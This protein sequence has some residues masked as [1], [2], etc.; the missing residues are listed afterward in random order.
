MLSARSSRKNK[1]KRYMTLN[2]LETSLYL[3]LKVQKWLERVFGIAADQQL[4]VDKLHGSDTLII[5]E[6]IATGLNPLSSRTLIVAEGSL[7]Y[8]IKVYN[9]KNMDFIHIYN[10]H[11]EESTFAFRQKHYHSWN[12]ILTKLQ[13][14]LFV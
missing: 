4:I 8:K 10:V 2:E 3:D 6:Q 11:E 13:K 14:T 5:F 9:Y 1:N 7:E 12:T